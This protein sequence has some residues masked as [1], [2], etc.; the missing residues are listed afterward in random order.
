ME[1]PLTDAELDELE[2]QA[3]EFWAAM[4]AGD[5]DTAYIV[6]STCANPSMLCMYVAGVAN[7]SIGDMERV[8]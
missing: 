8:G 4:Q 7:E 1:V 5:L 3:R 2:Q 6:S